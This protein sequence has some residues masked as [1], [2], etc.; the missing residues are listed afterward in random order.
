MKGLLKIFLILL[1]LIITSCSS[2]IENDD[3]E[4]SSII[5]TSNNYE[6]RALAEYLQLRNNQL[7]MELPGNKADT[8][9]YIKGPEKQLMV[10]DNDKFGNFISFTNPKYVIVLGNETYVPQKYLSRINKNM[11]TIILND[12][13]WRLIA[14]QLEELTDESGLAE[15]YIKTLDELV[16]SGTIPSHN[17]SGPSEPQILNPVN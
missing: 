5:I 4:I 1:P 8:K 10:I 13:D 6:S 7:I 3:E 12:S 17:S 16:R 14:W 9:V 2:G 15:E 11:K